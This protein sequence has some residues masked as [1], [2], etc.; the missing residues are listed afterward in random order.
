MNKYNN[1]FDSC[2]KVNR[3][4]MGEFYQGHHIKLTKPTIKQKQVRGYK[5]F[6]GEK[7]I[8]G[9]KIV[10]KSLSTNR[11]I[12]CRS[13]SKM[14]K[15]SLRTIPA[16][17]HQS[18][19]LAIE[20]Q[21]RCAR[22]DSY[23]LLKQKKNQSDLEERLR[24]ISQLKSDAKERLDSYE[25]LNQKNHKSKIEEKEKHDRLESYKL[26]KRKKERRES[27]E[28]LNQKSKIDNGMRGLDLN[29]IRIIEGRDEN[30]VRDDFHV[31]PLHNVS[32]QQD[33]CMVLFYYL[34]IFYCCYLFKL[35]DDKLYYYTE[36]S[37]FLI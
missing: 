36:Y 35:M 30:L 13:S 4:G 17:I 23:E 10:I 31:K 24:E 26:L 9:G 18:R 34:F 32:S 20:E 12:P 29:D 27:Y 7:N 25:L 16:P 19:Q 11:T 3:P 5:S 6:Q 14:S 37:F 8:L 28:L 22:R 21:E 33:G 15:G 2:D 1:E